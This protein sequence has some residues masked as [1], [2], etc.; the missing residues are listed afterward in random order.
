MLTVLLQAYNVKTQCSYIMQDFD[1]V[2][3]KNIYSPN[4]LKYQACNYNLYFPYFQNQLNAQKCLESRLHEVLQQNRGIYEN[5]YNRIIT[6]SKISLFNGK[7][8]IIL[9]IHMIIPRLCSNGMFQK[10]KLQQFD[11][12]Q[13]PS[14]NTKFDQISQHSHLII[15]YIAI[16]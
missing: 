13:N 15:E 14:F 4:T 3:L 16:I 2:Q 10:R 1:Q 8:V 11:S 5:D 9:K 6:F 7:T 12:V